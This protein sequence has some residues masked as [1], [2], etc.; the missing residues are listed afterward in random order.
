MPSAGRKISVEQKI[1]EKLET[2]QAFVEL[3]INLLD[4]GPQQLNQ[5]G[6]CE[7]I[8]KPNIHM[9]EFAL[10]FSV[11]GSIIIKPFNDFFFIWMF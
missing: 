4:N 11:A 10:E 9:E 7:L 2:D 3:K 8:L 5:T 1:P 6:D